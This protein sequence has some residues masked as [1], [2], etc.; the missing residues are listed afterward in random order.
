[1]HTVSAASSMRQLNLPI[2]Q[3]APRSFDSF[4]AGPNELALAQLREIAAM[5]PGASATPVY[6]WG[7]A[8]CGKTHLLQALAA[9]FGAAGVEVGRFDGSSAPLPWALDDRCGLIIFDGC[10][11]LDAAH[12]QAAFAQFVD[13]SSRGARVAAA[14]RVPPVDLPLRDDLR[15]RLGWGHVLALQP[16]AEAD[17]RTVL[18]AEALRRGLQ[19]S[20]EVTAYVLSHFARDLKSLMT[21]F[22]RADDFAL[23]QQRALTVPLMRQLQSEPAPSAVE[24]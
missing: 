24:P 9:A 12:Q 7:P 1:M 3:A 13:A 4:V 8:G 18:R 2:R 16:L 5:R 15:S 21:L 23:S 11:D 6:L 19:L 20:D 17:V 14:G 22:N 10:D